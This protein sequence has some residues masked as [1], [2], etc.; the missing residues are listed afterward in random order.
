MERK[1]QVG[2]VVERRTCCDGASGV[3]NTKISWRSLSCLLPSSGDRREGE[4]A[5]RDLGDRVDLI[6]PLWELG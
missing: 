6:K 3:P 2:G 5:G 4:P 1:L